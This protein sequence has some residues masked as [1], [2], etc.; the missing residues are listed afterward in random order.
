MHCFGGFAVASLCLLVLLR[1]T[2]HCLTGYMSLVT[3]YQH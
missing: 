1:N 2:Q 3:A